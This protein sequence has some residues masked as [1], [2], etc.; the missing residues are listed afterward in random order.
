MILKAQ[1]GRGEKVHLLVDGIYT[2][3]TTMHFWASAGIQNGA[4]LSAQEVNDL[5]GKVAYQKMYD[6]ALFLL[7]TRDYARKELEEKLV[8]K[9]LEKEYRQK[10]EAKAKDSLSKKATASPA[11]DPM[12]E[13]ATDHTEECLPNASITGPHA[14]ADTHAQWQEADRGRIRK[15]AALVCDRLEELGL[16]NDEKFARLYATEL[17]QKKQ[18]AARGITAKLREKGIRQEVIDTVLQ[19]LDP[20][21]KEAIL[22][23]L[24]TKFKKRNLQEEKERRRTAAALMRM[25]YQPGEV[26]SVM[27]TF[28]PEHAEDAFLDADL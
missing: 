18:L 11:A 5:L 24:Q 13:S 20:D 12:T 21:E 6:K 9:T 3:T 23:L 4:D 8:R 19:E 26:Y 28:F 1:K 25:G 14:E 17:V 27:Q 2:A 10:K 7:T 16:V 15:N 22:T